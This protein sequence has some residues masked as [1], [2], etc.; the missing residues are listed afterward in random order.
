MPLSPK[1]N[2]IT[3]H[4]SRLKKRE[5]PKRKPLKKRLRLKESRERKRLPRRRPLKRLLRKK[6]RRRLPPRRPLR[7][8]LLK[9]PNKPPS[10]P[11]KRS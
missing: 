6:P 11:S 8:R 3:L 9:R 4:S 2:R 7:K 5:L 10:L 1:I